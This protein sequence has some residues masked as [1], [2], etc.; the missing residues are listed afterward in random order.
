[1][2]PLPSRKA[3]EAMKRADL[4]KLCKDYGVKANLKS[5]ALIDLLLDTQSAVTSTRHTTVSSQYKPP[6]TRRDISTRQSSR[7]GPSRTT[8]L[9]IHDTDEED[10]NSKHTDAEMDADN[11]RFDV[12]EPS[13]PEQSQQQHQTIAVVPPRTRK[14]KEL[15]RRL[16]MGKPVAA[17]GPGP[18]AVTRSTTLSRGKH[19]KV[20]RTFT[21]EATIPE[22]EP[23]SELPVDSTIQ[24]ENDEDA[25]SLKT[26]NLP[27]DSSKSLVSLTDIDE[28]V[29]NA[30]RP[31]HEQL[32]TLR[33]E[34]EQ[35]HLLRAD[36]TRLK[37]EV[38]GIKSL[39]PPPL[40]QDPATP[41][42]KVPYSK[43]TFGPGGLGMPSTMKPPTIQEQQEST[44]QNDESPLFSSNSALQRWSP[45]SSMLGKRQRDPSTT[46]V[47]SHT[48]DDDGQRQDELPLR[49]KPKT[50][51]VD[52]HECS[53]TMPYDLSEDER[54]SSTPTKETNPVPPVAPFTV[55]KESQEPPDI[56]D[57]MPAATCLSDYLSI[58]SPPGTITAPEYARRN[59]GLTTGASFPSENQNPFTFRPTSSTVAPQQYP[60]RHIP[61][62][63]TT[64]P[65]L[66]PPQ[67]PTPSGS[68]PGPSNVEHNADN[69][70]ALVDDENRADMFRSFGLPPLTRAATRSPS[71]V[72]STALATR[73]DVPMTSN[74]VA[75]G[76][77]LRTISSSSSVTL[78]P[79][80]AED[81]AP[82]LRVTMYGTEL[83]GDTRFGDFGVEGVATG[84]WTGGRF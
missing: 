79:L 54:M 83:D 37:N 60:H 19:G 18:R 63:M 41:S 61:S 20:S 31:L 69:E 62:S 70:G 53:E 44:S 36:L 49:K 7:A 32:Q 71:A 3:L 25:K 77:G 80:E 42:P 67:S 81:G 2:P 56:D 68:R 82:L 8:S 74:E 24:G 34:L 21:T 26:A 58:P 1:M 73:K 10:E 64:F 6:S 29:A 23:G 84:F 47:G 30:L 22:E 52:S 46:N 15:Q 35:M 13:S 40:P 55:F 76:L 28:R 4:Q 65:F 72:N 27:P 33:I 75:A 50:S 17:G 14:A 43:K 9:I 51:R 39:A 38:D 78:A 12:V 66:E 11:R 57:L 5:E 45:R 16:G 59:I 48:L